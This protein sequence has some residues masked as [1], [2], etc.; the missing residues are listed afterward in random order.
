MKSQEFKWNRLFVFCLLLA[1]LPGV[2]F[3]GDAMAWQRLFDGYYEG[4]PCLIYNEAG[5]YAVPAPG[6]LD[7]DGD[8]DILIGHQS[9]YPRYIRNDGTSGVPCWSFISESYEI[10]PLTSPPV[11]TAPF[12]ADGDQDGDPD[13]ILGLENGYIAYYRNEGT[14]AAPI[15]NLV[16]E[17]W[18]GRSG[19]KNARPCLTDI[20]AD[21]DGD[22]FVG[23]QSGH[24]SFYRNDAN[25]GE[26]PVWTWQLDNFMNIDAGADASPCFTDINGDGL[27][28]LFVG[29]SNGDIS[30]YKGYG[31][32]HLLFFTLV[33][34]QYENIKAP[35]NAA[36]VFFD[37]GDHGTRNLLV[38]SFAGSVQM[39]P[40][41]GTVS[42]PV[43]GNPSDVWLG[44]DTGSESA[45][46]LAD[47]DND[48]DPDFFIGAF[49]PALS[50]EWG[51][52]HY[53]NKG[54]P[55][56][57][58][59]H[60][61][62]DFFI[63]RFEEF[64]APRFV[65]IDAD[66]DLDL[67]TGGFSGNVL[68]FR[69]A[70]TA[71]FPSYQPEPAGDI[72]SPGLCAKPAFG[73]M[74][75]DLDYDLY[76]AFTDL[77]VG[78]VYYYENS[79]NS[80]SPS[81]AP[82]VDCSTIFNPG[83]LPA[84][85]TG[86][87][88]CDGLN[89]VICAWG[90]D[91]V[92]IYYGEA[93]ASPFSFST[94]MNLKVQGNMLHPVPCISDIN[95]DMRPDIILGGTY[96]GIRVYINPAKNASV[97]PHHATIP[98][99]SP[100]QLSAP[101][102]FPGVWEF[103]RNESGGTLDPSTGEYVSGHN[104]G[105][106]IIRVKD[107][108]TSWGIS[109][110]NVISPDQISLAGKAVI[111]A[112]RKENDPL[113]NTTNKLANDVYRTL[114]FLGFSKDNIYYLNP[115]ASQDVDANGDS[116]DDI[117][118]PSTLANIEQGL[119]VFAAGSPEIL[120]YLIDHGDASP[121]G[122]NGFIR[123][124]EEDILYACHLD[125][126]LDNLQEKDNVTT[127]TLVVDC[128]MAES[129]M[130]E[131]SGES[132]IVIT[133]TNL[134]HPAFFA[135]GGLISFT[136][137]FLSA[138]QQGHSA[139]EAF[140]IASGAMDRFQ[141]PQMDDDG[142]GFYVPGKDGDT[143]D[144]KIIGSSFIAGADH[145]FIDLISP[146]QVLHDG[147]TSCT[148]WASGIISSCLIEGV[149]ASIKSPSP[150]SS[151]GTCPSEPVPN[152][153]FLD[154]SWNPINNRYE[155]TTDTFT[156][157]GIYSVN[158]YAR[159]IWGSL[160]PPKQTYI[161]QP[162]LKEEMIIVCGDGDYAPDSPWSWIESLS[163]EAYQTARSKW[164]SDEKIHFLSSSSDSR[165][166]SPPT[167]QS[168]F[169]SIGEAGGADKLILYMIGKG[170]DTMFDM[171]GDGEDGDD[172]TPA[173][174]DAALD[175]L[176][177]TQSLIV[178]VILDFTGSG[179]WLSSLI[180]PDGK[181][182]IVISSSSIGEISHCLEGGVISFSG[183]FFGK[184]L[185]GSG[186]GDAFNWARTAIRTITDRFQNPQL[187]DNGSGTCDHED[188][189]LLEMT[190]IGAENIIHNQGP[191]IENYAKDIMVDSPQM[192][193]WA[194]DIWDADGIEE[195]FAIVMESGDHSGSPAT[196]K[197]PL[198][199][200]DAS[201]RWENAFS[202]FDSE[203]GNVILYMARDGK[204]FLSKPYQTRYLGRK[205]EDIYDK[206]YRDDHPR[207][208]RNFFSIDN[209]SQIH[210]FWKPGDEDWAVF[211]ADAGMSYSIQ[212]ISQGERC[213]AAL[214]MFHESDMNH[215][216]IEQ[217]DWGCGGLD[218]LISWHSGA[219]SGAIF[220]RV[221][222]SRFY[223]GINGEDTT[224]TLTIGGEW[225]PNAGLATISGTQCYIGPE[226][227]LLQAGASGIY[228][229]PA[230]NIPPDALPAA[231]EFIIDDPGDIGNNPYFEYTKAWLDQNPTNASIVQILTQ[232][233]VCFEHPVTL[234][235]Q[236]I[237]DGP[238]QGGFTIDDLPEGHEPS[239]MRIHTWNQS[240]WVLLSGN[241][242][243][244]EDTVWITLESL[245]TGLFA[246]APIQ[247]KPNSWIFY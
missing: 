217:D 132:R 244:A 70:G 45:P 35:G 201:S 145:P 200:N 140:C 52:R 55:W 99:E 32:P 65:D 102:I 238:A 24:I 129:F 130:R 66:G 186:M 51:I 192:L 86:D 215:P 135:A 37:S 246:V 105:R 156:L 84:I 236:F 198:Y 136:H 109:C 196:E 235:M 108:F 154:L 39:F 104:R 233:P 97:E 176:Q 46:E 149:W 134:S 119:G 211:N 167:R 4:L 118:A 171:D 76:I 63:S 100:L 150:S 182:R 1:G 38:G 36:P 138:L 179:G 2:V 216:L 107:S 147:K 64:T 110:V 157:P 146:N 41:H 71:N 195:V 133:S 106:D 121:E 240:K 214:T 94:P 96:G 199:F 172:L 89:D 29:N 11:R 112:G 185:N 44:L 16:T 18:T 234:T 143:A 91:S 47:I 103:I 139:G 203:N 151:S 56:I 148:L 219:L 7:G 144:H 237:D 10:P 224:Y 239:S 175:S 58:D 33:T 126:L 8:E 31:E 181:R 48:G 243:V 202:G 22:L 5:D 68:F 124:N 25:P 90:D 142:D 20:D 183:F 165:V 80:E 174:L 180:P 101:S 162:H 158:I 72:P 53:H 220:V 75:H 210:N 184:M 78:R 3:C 116:E 122:R 17:N 79:G 54:T 208:T 128:C 170:S 188:G 155:A 231:M 189:Y 153:G 113:W 95:G 205:G 98:T 190:G 21:G 93:P 120:I 221:S 229:K 225:G 15:W 19:G 160:S 127:I 178:V 114:L 241:Q 164:F 82:P 92:T 197:I 166:D 152:L 245:G 62:T 115:E 228:T 87:L 34:D 242:T 169:D 159:D 83:Q 14:A 125:E 9:G 26:S 67:F 232:A 27:T 77:G 117:D 191:V 204:G 23:T 207:T 61:E 49:N 226:G 218:E 12:L 177:K 81:W 111:M 28:D 213:D 131:C 13:L 42:L 57:S 161:S 247:I 193:L 222:Q 137:G 187:D 206:L 227:G 73:D 6:D 123:C 30:Y 209:F 163:L 43:F 59:W 50:H 212:A 173:E 60:R 141:K 85:D 74:D 40:N 230:A 69:N 168:L 223:P 88:D 194:S